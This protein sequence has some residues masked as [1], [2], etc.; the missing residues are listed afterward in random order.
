MS[1][2]RPRTNL[3]SGVRRGPLI[4]DH[5]VQSDY[6]VRRSIRRSQLKMVK[7]VGNWWWRGRF[8]VATLSQS[9]DGYIADCRVMTLT[10]SELCTENGNGRKLPRVK[11]A[12]IETIFR[13]M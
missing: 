9:T 5:F 12:E 7:L 2:D 13:K 4:V 3:Y 11:L 1:K 8:T 10:T 6:G